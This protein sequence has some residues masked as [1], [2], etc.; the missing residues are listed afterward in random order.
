MTKLMLTVSFRT[1]MPWEEAREYWRTVHR[2][3]VLAT[4]GIVAYTQNSKVSPV[5]ENVPWDGIV[6]ITFEDD[7]AFRAAMDSAHWAT[8]NADVPEFAQWSSV[9]TAIVSVESHR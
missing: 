5:T 3:M 7:D 9:A 1:D 2:D 8:V 4:P 6:E